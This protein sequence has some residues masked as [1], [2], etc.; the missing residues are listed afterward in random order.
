MEK[1]TAKEQSD[2]LDL[3][4]NAAGVDDRWILIASVTALRQ[5]LTELRDDARQMLDAMDARINA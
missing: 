5:A 4:R 2:L 3:A 1:M